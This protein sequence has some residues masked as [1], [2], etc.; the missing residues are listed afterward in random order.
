MILPSQVFA[1]NVKG[2]TA[3]IAA[4]TTHDYENLRGVLNA[5]VLSNNNAWASIAT[6]LRE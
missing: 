4:N 5:Q 6:V 1:L 3:V 2:G